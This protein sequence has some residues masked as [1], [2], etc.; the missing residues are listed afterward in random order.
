M[1]LKAAGCVSNSV[2]TQ[3]PHFAMSASVAQASLSGYLWLNTVNPCE[4]KTSSFY[5]H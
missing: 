1:G 4:L 5:C 2:D 3:I